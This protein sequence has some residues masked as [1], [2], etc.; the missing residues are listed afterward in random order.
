MGDVV[1]DSSASY[2]NYIAVPGQTAVR[3]DPV[4]D[5][6]P[7]HFFTIVSNGEPFIRHH[8]E[9]FSQL[10]F[11]WHW[12]IIEGVA[13]LKHAHI[14]LEFTFG[15]RITDEL[16][17][18]GLSND[19]TAEYLNDLVKQYPENITVYRKPTAHSGTANWKWSMPHF[20]PSKKSACCGK[21]T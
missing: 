3:Q 7:V 11:L 6:L 20:R 1:K 13:D 17:R 4:A 5:T 12:H 2:E 14:Q 10:P 8:I 15:G 9:V 16:H 21:S 19:G 18:N